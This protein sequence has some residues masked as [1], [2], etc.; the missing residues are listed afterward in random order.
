[1]NIKQLKAYV[2]RL[3]DIKIQVRE[4]Q[5]GTGVYLPETYGNYCSLCGE[6]NLLKQILEELGEVID[7]DPYET[8]KDDAGY[9]YWGSIGRIGRTE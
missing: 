3:L 9:N 7:Y 1:M 8:D 4:K 5:H 6:I 2:K